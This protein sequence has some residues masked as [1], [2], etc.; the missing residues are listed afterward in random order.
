[1]FAGEIGC[2]DSPYWRSFRKAFFE[3]VG[4]CELAGPFELARSAIPLL[5]SQ[6]QDLLSDV[7]VDFACLSPIELSDL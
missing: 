5:P 3:K 1:M 4:E 6:N 7:L 2:T